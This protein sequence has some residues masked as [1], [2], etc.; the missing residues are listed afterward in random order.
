MLRRVGGHLSFV[1]DIR[2]E[3]LYF[4]GDVTFMPL[5]RLPGSRANSTFNRFSVRFAPRLALVA[6]VCGWLTTAAPAQAPRNA[7]FES[8]TF[9]ITKARLVVSPEEEI[10]QG[11]IVVR[12]GLI[13]AIGKDV[14]I[15]PDAEI[16]DG[17][18]LTVYAGF[19][20]AA[21]TSMLDPNRNAAPSAGRPID[22]SRFALAATPPDN[23][24]SLT[25]EFEAAQGLKTDTNAIEARR[26]IGIT[27]LHVTPSGKIAGGRGALLTTSG[28]PLRESL[29]APVTYP[30]FQLF[31]PRGGGYPNTLMGATA[32]LR[33]AFLDARRFRQH[34]RFYEQQVPGIARPPE[35]P[36]LEALGEIAEKHS[37]SLFIVN[38][39]DDIHRALDFA[40]E[41][42]VPVL[43]WGARESQFCLDRVKSSAKGVIAQVNWG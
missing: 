2:D 1:A 5:F 43:L 9:A 11:T 30:Q 18:T 23:R 37:T 21:S 4:S 19:V 40:A 24:K 26:K 38:G 29:L 36:V 33:Q 13:A 20:D 39:Q 42:Q 8:T 28:L 17:A 25:P 16:I 34:Q 3:L 41:Q 22:F 35:D 14:A 10:E 27:T 6:L 31:G 32:H 12:D 7:G 15:P